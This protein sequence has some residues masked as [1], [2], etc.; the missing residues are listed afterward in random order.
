[1]ATEHNVMLSTMDN[2]INPFVDFSGWWHFDHER[3]HNCCELLARVAHLSDDMTEL[4]KDAECERAIDEIIKHD[5]LGIYRK[6]TP[7]TDC[8]QQQWQV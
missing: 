7:Q 1:M 4:E 8:S 6:V 5:E 3:K 2:K